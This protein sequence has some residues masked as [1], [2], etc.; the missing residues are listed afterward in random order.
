MSDLNHL[1]E[2]LKNELSK[3]DLDYNRVESLSQLITASDKENVRFSIDARHIHRLG[4]ELVGKQETALSELIKNAYDADA[5]HVD[6]N[7]L[8]YHQ[9]GGTCIISDD[10][11]GMPEEIIRD[12]WMRLSTSD[13]EDNPI[14]PMFGRS[15]AGR[16]GIGR[17]AVERLGEQLILETSV[18]GYE[19][20][21][22]VIF[23]WDKQYQHGKS[24]TQVANQLERFS[25]PKKDHGTK[26][27]VKKLRD[28]WTDKTLERVW[29]S[30][31]LLQPP[32][33]APTKSRETTKEPGN[34]HIDPGFK[35]TINGKLGNEVAQELSIEKTFLENRLALIKGRIDENGNAFYSI[36]SVKL[37]FEDEIGLEN[38]SF[39]VGPLEFEASYFI[40]A[41]DLISGISLKKAVDMGS[42]WGG[43]RIYRDGFRV[44]PYGEP[45]DDWLKLAYDTGRRHIIVPANNNHYFG[46]IELSSIDNPLF[47]ET[48]SREGL[49]ENEAYEEMRLFVRSCLEGAALRIAAVRKRKQTAGQKDFE[50]I[51]P[52]KKPSEIIQEIL[53]EASEDEDAGASSEEQKEKTWERLNQAKEQVKKFEEETDQKEQQRIQYEEML[54][55]LASLGLSISVFGHEVKGGLTRLTN[56]F[57]SLNDHLK[58]T[59]QEYEAQTKDTYLAE[60]H[61]G[62]SRLHDLGAYISAQID[63]T[64]ARD[65][66]EIP[67]SGRIKKFSEQF[68]DYLKTRSIE[69]VY[70][71][72]PPYLRTIPMHRSEIDSVLFNF[73]TNSIKAIE[74]SKDTNRQIQVTAKLQENYAVISFQD[75]GPGVPVKIAEHIFDPFFTTTDYHE[76]EIAGPGSGLG[77]KIVSDIASANGGYVRLAKPEDGFGCRFDFGV[78]ISKKQYR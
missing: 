51:I 53:D 1:K 49:I 42:K 7:F 60:M 46:H 43:L 33:K 70:S 34:Y 65:K 4:F 56:T 62:L 52:K 74:R 14:S 22:R 63:S 35:V 75:T 64:G 77:L 13:K 9:S 39:L 37:G 67:L 38:K 5:N 31:L 21:I 18:A 8:D 69:L 59:H 6:I 71:V 54:R 50:S 26:L 17:F 10:G 32:F 2:A 41:A 11:H 20:G 25:K 23:D 15:R 28:R 3:E 29:K 61:E 73:L 36:K 45:Q 68:A 76:D 78:P 30:V 44:L 12:T 40:Y 55:I 19:E 27:I 47:E 16:K 58:K 57:D 24:L 48:S 72:D 66:Q